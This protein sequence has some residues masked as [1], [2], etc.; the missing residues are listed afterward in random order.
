MS[1]SGPPRR[2]EW[3]SDPAVRAGFAAAYDQQPGPEAPAAPEPDEPDVRAEL[4]ARRLVAGRQAPL[5]PGAQARR[6]GAVHA[7]AG[8]ALAVAGVCLGILALLWVTGDPAPTAQD[9]VAQERALDDPVAELPLTELPVAEEPPPP[10]PAPA[11]PVTPAPAPAAPAPVPPPPPPAPSPAAQP[12]SPVVPVT[13]LNNS[14]R[15]G[16]A[17]R[18]AARFEAGGWPVTAT[19]NLRGRIPVTTVYYD[20]GL[21]ASAQAFAASFDGVARVLPRFASLPARGVVV[22]VT[23]EFPVG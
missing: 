17:D 1:G 13:V 4:V 20:Q 19:G 22:V 21:E 3:L 15:T 6:G 9:A 8:A 2:P 10:P 5:G 11:V 18:A 12:A 14:R 16:L 23:R 7:L